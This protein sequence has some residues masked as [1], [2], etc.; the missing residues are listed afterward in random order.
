MVIFRCWV[1][2]ADLQCSLVIGTAQRA[3]IINLD[4]IRHAGNAAQRSQMTLVA[5]QLEALVIQAIRGNSEKF[6]K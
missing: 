6:D 4:A 1:A 3:A 5:H 2:V